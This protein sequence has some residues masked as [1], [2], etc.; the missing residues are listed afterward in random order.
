MDE[1]PGEVEERLVLRNNSGPAFE[2]K[3]PKAVSVGERA[4]PGGRGG[5]GL[6]HG[7]WCQGIEAGHLRTN[8]SQVLF[9][10]IL[11][12]GPSGL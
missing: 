6:D 1:E 3:A 9:H 5:Q 8:D 12:A 4:G 7:S 11:V 2:S 10:K